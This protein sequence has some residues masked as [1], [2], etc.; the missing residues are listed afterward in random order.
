MEENK[1][2]KEMARPRAFR[3]MSLLGEEGDNTVKS[4]AI[5]NDYREISSS[6]KVEVTNSRENKSVFSLFLKSSGLPNNSD[7]VE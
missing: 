5:N 7:R 1:K 6:E 3:T 4:S 2:K